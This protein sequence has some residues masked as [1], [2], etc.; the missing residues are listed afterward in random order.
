[1]LN[2]FSK[3]LGFTAQGYSSTGHYNIFRL[4]LISCSTLSSGCAANIL[5]TTFCE[6][7]RTKP[8]ITKA[9]NASSL[10]VLFGPANNFISSTLDFPIL[11][12][13]SIITLCAVFAAMKYSHLEWQLSVHPEILRIASC[14]LYWPQYP[15]QISGV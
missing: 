9:D 2:S 5:S 6:A 15:K 11:S 10:T 14:V 8:S 3:T 4:A 7:P 13:S 1:M 12:F